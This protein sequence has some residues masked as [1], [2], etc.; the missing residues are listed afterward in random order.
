M[1]S[2]I[3]NPTTGRKVSIYGKIGKK[4]LRNYIILLGGANVEVPAL[5]GPNTSQR[6]A[7]DTLAIIGHQHNANSNTDTIAVPKN[8]RVVFFVKDKVNM[9][10]GPGGLPSI[11]CKSTS[12]EINEWIKDIKPDNTKSDISVSGKTKSVWIAGEGH[13]ITDYRI[14]VN[15]PIETMSKDDEAVVGR[16][17]NSMMK[18][19]LFNVPIDENDLLPLYK[20]EEN[21]VRDIVTRS[22]YCDLSVSRTES[23]NKVA[24]EIFN[25]IAIEHGELLEL[26]HRGTMDNFD[27]DYKI[28]DVF[29]MCEEDPGKEFIILFIAC[30]G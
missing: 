1:Y 15:R 25:A 9:G 6:D 8:V 16:G 12:E 7:T 11:M 23:Q 18:S 14:Q 17:C 24:R 10:S 27:N 30:R 3:V 19:G 13:S 4:I 22:T 28:S 26:A 29:T 5:P 2:K 21:G 20:D